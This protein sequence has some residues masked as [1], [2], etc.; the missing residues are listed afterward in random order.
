MLRNH[1]VGRTC[2]AA[3]AGPRFT[4]RNLDEEVLCTLFGIL[5]EDVEVTI[6]GKYSGVQQ[7]VFHVAAI[8]VSIR[9]DQIEIGICRLRI[10]VQV[11][12]VRVRRRA[13]EIKVVFLNVFAVVGLAVGEPERAFFENW[14]FTIPQGHAKTQQLL[15]ITD[16]SKTV[17][18]PVVG[19]GAGLVM[20]KVIPRVSILAV[21]LADRTPLALTKV[22]TPFFPRRLR[23]SRLFQSD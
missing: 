17:F 21:V 2:R 22:G 9:L 3:G 19:S 18:A 20:C 12:H 5:H 11:L 15:V 13:V 1:R 4:T 23:D 7:F 8:A 10:F 16:A 14:I 6:L